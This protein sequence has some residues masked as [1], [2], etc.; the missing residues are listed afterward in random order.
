MAAGRRAGQGSVR[1][2]E[3]SG[4]AGVESKTWKERAADYKATSSGSFWKVKGESG[5]KTLPPAEE[6][7]YTGTMYKK[8]IASR[9]SGMVPEFYA[10]GCGT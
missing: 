9:S 6:R 5:S 10:C 2:L 7:F 4:S 1:I 8:V 3:G